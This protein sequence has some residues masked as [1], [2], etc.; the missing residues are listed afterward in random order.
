MLK[1]QETVIILDFG[2]QYS[3]LIARRVRE[4]HIYCEILPYDTPLDKILSKNPKAVIL[5]GGPASVYSE[6]AP[7]CDKKLFSCGVPILGIC[8][9]MQLMCHV[10]GG[11][12]EPAKTAEYGRAEL[13]VDEEGGLF[14]GLEKNLTVWMSHGDSILALPEGFKTLAHTKNTPHAAISNGKNLFGVQFHPEVAHTP[15]GKEILCNFLFGIAGCSGSWSTTS[16]VEE[17]VRLIKER[18]GN[19]RALCAL[20]GGVDSSVAALIT[21]KAIGEN[22]TCIFVDH[23]LL[24]KGEAQ[25][26]INTFREKFHMNLI[27]VDASD[28]FLNRL[29]GITDP[30]QKR[31]IIG[32]EFIRV[33]EEE[34]KKLGSVDF[35]V[36]GTVYPDVIESGTKTAAVIKSHHNVGG[37][38]KDLKFEL[39]EPLRDLFKDEV[40]KVGLE[41]GLPEEIVYRHPFPGPGLA[42]R[43]L[44]EVTREKLEIL[45][46]ADAIVTEEIKKAGIY[47]ELWQAFAVLTNVK[48]VGVMGDERTYAYTIAIRA[49]K[50][51]D[52]MTADWA[53]LPYEVLDRISTRI[54]NEVPHVNRVVYDITSKPPATIEW[55]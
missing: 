24:R 22:L 6:K 2:G 34:A 41:L 39:I 1:D 3:Q 44:G 53:R 35:L 29:K 37:L 12:V 13:L 33:F 25:Q 18:V 23:G 4:A 38:P 52:G 48:S 50:S 30:E 27:A 47:G 9:G 42:V 14:N 17:Q 31:K 16:F 43:I 15:K 11:R 49:V 40:R 8:Y 21:H 7:V 55:E 36:Q 32:E 5:S 26:V 46:E 45:R 51:E 54:A 20:S 10:L 28:R 19:K